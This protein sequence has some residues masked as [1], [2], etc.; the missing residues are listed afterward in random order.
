MTEA[1]LR[2]LF[3]TPYFRPYLGGIERAIEQLTFQIQE[4]Q[5]V[6]AV[7][8]LTTKYAFPRV[9]HPEWA[10][11]ETTEE[12]IGIYRLKGFPKRSIPLYSCPLVW[13]SPMQVR[14]FLKEFDPDVVHFVGDGCF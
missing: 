11:K 10:D 3:L 7:A 12:G 6:E 8:V 1:P 9:P 4:S 13:F 2:V 14:S 5:Q